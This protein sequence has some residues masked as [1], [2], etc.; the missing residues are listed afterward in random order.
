MRVAN[1]YAQDRPIFSFEFF[2]PRTP[3]GAQALLRTT[4]ELARLRP[5]FISVTCPLEKARRPDTFALVIQI[6]R[7]LGIETMAHLVTVD[8]DR[9]EMAEILAELR[10][11]G[12]ENVL[13]LRGD[14]PDGADPKAPRDFR[15]GV[16]LARF[17]HEFG[18]LCIG[19]AAHPERHPESQ[20]WEGEIRHAREKVDAGCEFLVTQLFFDN[21]D[22]FAYVERARSAGIEVPI[23]PGIMPVGSVPGI[24]RMAAMNGNRIP[25]DFLAE[26]EDA[27]D[28]DAA[29]HALG[30]Q[31][32]TAQCEDLLARGVPGIHFYT[33]NRS[34]ATREILTTLRDRGAAPR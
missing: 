7:D 24:Q 31:H 5:D 14:L 22:Y 9:R 17:A 21:E 27:R 28:D 8:Y 1:L 34:P 16:D 18:G 23:V 4:K 6:K 13:A 33:L 25:A 32:A 30:V 29:V 12:V 10:A 15:H 2:P 19:G 20:D 3:K 11:G 26:L